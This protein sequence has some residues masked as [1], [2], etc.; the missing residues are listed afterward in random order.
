MEMKFGAIMRACREKAGLT[1]EQLA[2]KLNRTQACVSKFEKDHKVPDMNTMLNWAEVTGAREVIVT[3]LYGMDG[4][5][6]I[7]RLMGG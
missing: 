4:I 1:Q 2:D 5:G 7:Q 6:M 3:F